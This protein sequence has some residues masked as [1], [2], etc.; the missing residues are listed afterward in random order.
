MSKRERLQREKQMRE[1]P[2]REP[3]FLKI[4]TKSNFDEMVMQ[5]TSAWMIVFIDFNSPAWQAVKEDYNMTAVKLG[6]KG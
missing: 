6:S 4:L 1:K 3:T 2:P 5:N